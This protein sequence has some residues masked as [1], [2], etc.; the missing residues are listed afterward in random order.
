ME[1][2]GQEH[3]DWIIIMACNLI[4]SNVFSHQG[5]VTLFKKGSFCCPTDLLS[6]NKDG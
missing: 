3:Q 4:K 6:I 2:L 5:N 1:L